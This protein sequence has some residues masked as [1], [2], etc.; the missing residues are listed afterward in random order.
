MLRSSF[1]VSTVYT[2]D[3]CGVARATSTLTV[4]CLIGLAQCFELTVLWIIGLAQRFES[5]VLCYI[6]L[7][8]C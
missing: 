4:L 7:A 3:A 1:D 2:G 6:G 8:A 5:T